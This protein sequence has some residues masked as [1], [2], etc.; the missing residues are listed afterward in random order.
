M[1]DGK[2]EEN[3]GNALRRLQTASAIPELEKGNPPANGVLWKDTLYTFLYQMACI[4]LLQLDWSLLATPGEAMEAVD[5]PRT[6]LPEK[7]RREAVAKSVKEEN[8]T[9]KASSSSSSEDETKASGPELVETP[10]LA[11]WSEAFFI[12]P[13]TDV[14]ENIDARLLRSVCFDRV[15]ASIRANHAYLL[16]GVDRGDLARLVMA[17]T[18][19]IDGHDAARVY[20]AVCNLVQIKKVG[21]S[22]AEFVAKISGWRLVVSESGFEFDERLIREAVLQSLD[23]D[24]LY[25]IEVALA[26]KQDNMS[27]DQI[28]ASVLEKS[29]SVEDSASTKTLS[30]L[31]VKADKQNPQNPC[32]NMRDYGKCRYGDECRFSHVGTGAPKKAAKTGGDVPAT[33]TQRKGCFEC[34]GPHSISEC[35]IFEDRKEN[36]ATLKAE[37]AEAR[38]MVAAVAPPSASMATIS[39][40][41]PN[42][43]TMSSLWGDD[44]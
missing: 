25:A 38:A 3:S 15:M 17:V 16:T 32:F 26:R 8:G 4:H 7:R 14:V 24:L 28:I 33:R 13:L 40:P 1:G 12:D 29:R 30:G 43:A 39:L 35:K 11:P 6:K 20:A 5:D 34:G 21:M 9:K 2:Y 44:C 41:G 31:A 23:S 37:L 19:V 42:A 18:R 36:E 10:L 27:L 22:A